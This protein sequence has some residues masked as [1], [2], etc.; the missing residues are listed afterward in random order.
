MK[1][2]KYQSQNDMARAS[3]RNTQ[4]CS[5][6]IRMMEGMKIINRLKFL[7]C[8]LHFYFRPRVILRQLHVFSRFTFTF[9][10][11]GTDRNESIGI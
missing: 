2:E 4:T 1:M 11:D 8:R 10:F 7:Q 9:N 5:W 3:L 6:V